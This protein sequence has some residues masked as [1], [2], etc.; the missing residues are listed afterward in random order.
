MNK[1]KIRIFE[2]LRQGTQPADI[3]L[4]IALGLTLGTIPILGS[5]TLLCAGAAL[6]LRLNMPL[7]ML[8]SYF[9]YPMQLLLYI[10]LLLLGANLL[11]SSLQSLTLTGVFTMLKTDIFGAIQRLFWAN[12]G[13]VLIWGAAALPLGFL[14]HAASKR[15]M[16]N[17]QNTIGLP[18]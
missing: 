3:A 6:S 1:L 5:T 14:V 16:R 13:A 9:V 10:P 11:D 7:I 8:I 2:L 12:L 4:T 17:F 15:L 18:Q